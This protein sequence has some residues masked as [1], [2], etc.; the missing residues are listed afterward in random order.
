MTYVILITLSKW[1]IFI[2]FCYQD[3]D[4]FLHLTL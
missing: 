1:L 2:I 3:F 4:Q